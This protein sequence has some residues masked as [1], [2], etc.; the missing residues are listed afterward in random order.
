MSLFAAVPQA[1]A[2][3]ILGVTEAFAS[4]TRPDKVNL[5]VGVYLGP[6]GKLPLMAAVAQANQQ[7]TAAQKPYGYQPID[8]TAAYRAAVQQLV[9]GAD[10]EAVH[11]GRITTIDTLGGTGALREAAD[12]THLVPNSGKVLISDPSWENHQA[13]F[14]RAGYDVSSYRYYDPLLHG[15]DFDQM[16]ADLKAAEPGTVVVLHACCHNPT[17]YDLT[18]QQWDR[19][20]PVVAEAGLI[21]FVDMAYQGFGSGIATDAEVVQKFL[22]AGLEFYCGT[23]SSKNFGLYGERVGAL[24]VVSAT[25][26]AAE[27]VRSQLKVLVRTT[28]SNPP[29]TG[30]ALVARIL[31]DPQLRAV[32]ETEL[33]QMR[34]RIK[35]LREQLVA[36]LS[37]HGVTDMGFIADQVGMFSYSGLSAEQMTQLRTDHGVYGTAAG[38]MCVAALNDTNLDHVAAAIAAVR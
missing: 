36:A 23:S 16:L 31:D 29:T 6:D 1:P 37:S 26:D 4:D 30:A 33:G 27:A 19:V 3:P 25:H 28:Y 35:Q 38:R 10:C 2:D 8:G 18:S 34:S 11:S 12:F 9:F 7:L 5:G 20:I 17:G 24:H 32:W 15:I 13:I 21:P 14:T 22:A